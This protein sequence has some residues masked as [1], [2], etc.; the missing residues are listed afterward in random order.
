VRFLAVGTEFL[1]IFLQE[2]R[3]DWSFHVQYSTRFNNDYKLQ[4]TYTGK[5]EDNRLRRSRCASGGKVCG[6]LFCGCFPYF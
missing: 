3:G 5:F 2:L 4:S 1:I 6:V